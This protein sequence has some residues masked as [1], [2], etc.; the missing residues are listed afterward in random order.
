MVTADGF[1]TGGMFGSAMRLTNAFLDRVFDE[2]VTFRNS[3][4]GGGGDGDST[5]GQ[6]ISK[7]KDGESGKKA[8]SGGDGEMDYRL[9]LDFVL[10]VESMGTRQGLQY[11][12]KLLNMSGRGLDGPT[13]AYFFRD[14]SKT[15]QEMDGYDTAEVA[16]VIDEIFD[17]VAP[18]DPSII[19]FEDL[20][21]SKAGP[22]VVSMLIDAEGFSVYDRRESLNHDRDDDEA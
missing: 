20:C 22:T 19:T 3:S 18:T 16:D 17:M 8:V 10:A 7:E 6:E 9:F 15:L 1:V 4:G 13:I 11:F 14:V 2:L 21:T 12:W 5:A